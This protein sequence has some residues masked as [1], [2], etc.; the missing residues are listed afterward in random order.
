MTDIFRTMI[1]PAS[2]TTLAQ[3]ITA[4]ETYV[5]GKTKAFTP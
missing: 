5:N 2:V 1:L 3:Q 4:T